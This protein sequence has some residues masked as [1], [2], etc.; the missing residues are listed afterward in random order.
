M[1]PADI[2]AN[3]IASRSK[4]ALCPFCGSE[5]WV[6]ADGAVL[7]GETGYRVE[8]EGRCHAMTCYWHTEQQAISAWNQRAAPADQCDAGRDG[9]QSLAEQFKEA[10]DAYPDTKPL[11]YLC[12]RNSARL[13]AIISSDEADR[14][15]IREALKA[16]NEYNRTRWPFDDELNDKLTAALALLGE[17]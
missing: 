8:C 16:A 2:L 12:V 10:L 6:H 7:Q 14:A 1:T 4:L 17:G 11:A 13:M 5:A 15:A 9:E 3:A